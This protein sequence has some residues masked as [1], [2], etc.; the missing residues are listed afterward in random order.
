MSTLRLVLLILTLVLVAFLVK[1]SLGGGET[2]A[3]SQPAR[4][5]D[6]VRERTHEIEGELKKKADRAQQAAGE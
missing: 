5:L 4:Q 3:K 6:Q 1:V 2:S